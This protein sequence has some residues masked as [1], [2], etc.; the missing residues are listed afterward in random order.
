MN[1]TFLKLG[2]LGVIGAVVH[3]VGAQGWS[4]DKPISDRDLSERVRRLERQNENLE[5]TFRSFEIEVSDRLR[6]LERDAGDNPVPVP[7]EN[8]VVCRM[9]DSFRSSSFLGRGKTELSADALARQECQKSLHSSYCSS[10]KSQCEVEQPWGSAT[11]VVT[12]GFRSGTFMADAPT[13]IEAAHKAQKLCEASLH[14]SY[15]ATNPRCESSGS[16]PTRPR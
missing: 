11:C 7:V 6:R 16:T 4:P 3:N 12:D 14:S 9:R 2:L 10:G 8:P 15:C 13:E 1:K 5:R